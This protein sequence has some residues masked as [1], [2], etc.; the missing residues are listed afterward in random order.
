ML[1]GTIAYVPQQAWIQNATL[2]GNIIFG[3]EFNAEKYEKV[4]D[5]CA[6][7]PDLKMLPGGD[8]IEI[9]EKVQCVF[10]STVLSSKTKLHTMFNWVATLS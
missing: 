1:Q 8:Q 4:I 6:L 2:K 10:E 5:V 7:R 3:K 9:G